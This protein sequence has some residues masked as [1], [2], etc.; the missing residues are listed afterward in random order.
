M[1]KPLILALVIA[2]SASCAT[3]QT[4]L[5]VA[6]FP[7]TLVECDYK[8]DSA[9]KVSFMKSQMTTYHPPSF[10]EF[11]VYHITD[12]KGK[13]WSINQFEWEDYSCIETIIKG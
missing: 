4:Q 11:T 12:I 1:F 8:Y 10:P 5:P 2:L 7:T 9:R 13:H 3:V 6:A